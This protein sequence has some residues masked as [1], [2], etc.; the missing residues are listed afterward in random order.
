MLN[1]RVSSAKSAFVCLMI[2]ARALTNTSGVAAQSSDPSS[3][4]LLSSG[5]LEYVGGFRVPGE[6][7]N[8]QSF[9]YGGQ[10]VA[11]DPA[12]NSLF[13]SSSG[14]VAE[15]SIPDP[16]NSSDVNALPFARFLQ[17]FVDPTE[18]HLRDV[19]ASDVKM[20]GLMV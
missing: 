1:I 8:G 10:A 17:S 14:S 7:V 3:L 19:D 5:G 13:L 20:E 2:V 9:A 6:T 15:I 4:P 18:G 16:V 12:T 11:Y